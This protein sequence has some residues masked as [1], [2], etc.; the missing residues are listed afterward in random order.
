MTSLLRLSLL[1]LFFCLVCLPLVVLPGCRPV[2]TGQIPPQS[3]VPHPAQLEQLL[4]YTGSVQPIHEHALISPIDATLETIHAHYGQFVTQGMLIFTLNSTE[5]QKRYDDTVTEYLKAK[6][7]FS[8][9]RAKFN[10]TQELWRAGLLSKNNYLSEK[11]SLNT[12]RVRLMQSTRNVTEL[13]EQMGQGSNADDELAGLS[14]S[15]LDKVHLA[16]M[17]KHNFIQLKSPNNGILLYPPKPVRNSQL[18]RAGA[19]VKRGQVLAFIGDMR[20]IRIDIDI[21]EVDIGSIQLGMPAT[22]KGVGFSKYVLHGQLVSIN[23]EASDKRA[24]G[25]PS[26]KASIEIKHLPKKAQAM[27]RVGMSARVDIQIPTI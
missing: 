7:S 1:S 16:L 9:A 19:A 8:V 17:S 14:F 3:L 4:H 13:L 15:E 22:I 2:K 6:D 18:L 25:L 10:G 27:I 11:S 24:N 23:A 5:L 21:P 12:E 20:G 26:F